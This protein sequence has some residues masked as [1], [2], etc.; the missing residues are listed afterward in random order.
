MPKDI[1]IRDN[2]APAPIAAPPGGEGLPALD[3]VSVEDRLNQLQAHHVAE[4]AAFGQP[5][6]VD[7]DE[8]L[9]LLAAD[10]IARDVEADNMRFETDD[11]GEFRIVGNQPEPEREEVWVPPAMTETPANR[12]GPDVA[13]R[14]VVAAREPRWMPIRELGGYLGA[15]G[16]EA[17]RTLGRTVFRTFPC[18]QHMERLCRAQQRDP[19][20]EVRVI[21]DS[22]NIPQANTAAELETVKQYVRQNGQAVTE[23]H[24]DFGR[25]MPGYRPRVFLAVSD[26]ETFLMVEELPENGAPAQATYIYC[27]AGGRPYYT[28]FLRNEAT[29]DTTKRLPGKSAAEPKTFVHPRVLAR[30][31][32]ITQLGFIE[33][34]DGANTV[35]RLRLDDGSVLT[36]RDRSGSLHDGRLE[37]IVDSKKGQSK[38]SFETS[39]EMVDWLHRELRITLEQ[40]NT[41]KA[42]F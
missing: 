24:I 1:A 9:F 38:T 27:W 16:G 28:Q 23:N 29:S 40:Q 7:P 25:V 36:V 41:P 13:G 11:F 35:T 5:G 3:I 14:A 31:A 8:A 22:P 19:L 21:V 37:I 2:A 10:D 6:Y 32:N 4:K 26:N 15:Q 12:P 20:G 42:R 30:N 39:Q 17:I 33:E 18:Y 34:K